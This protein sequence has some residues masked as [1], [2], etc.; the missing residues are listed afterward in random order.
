M[1][2]NIVEEIFSCSASSATAIIAG[3]RQLTFRDLEVLVDQ[4]AVQLGADGGQRIGLYCPNGI[5]HIVWSLAVLKCGGVLVPI[6]PELSPF[7]RD[8]Q[9]DITGVDAILCAD[10]RKWHKIPPHRRAL[11][12]L[13]L[14]T[15]EMTTG[16]RFTA[17]CFDENA[18]ASL[19]PAL[20]RF[21]SGTTGTSK[22]VV[23]SHQTLLDR[24]RAS[25]SH[26][27]L[28]P[29]DRV[30]WMLPMAHHF[31]VS[32]ILYLLHGATTVLENSHLGEDVF[33]AL[34]RH[35][36]TA[37]YASPFHY[38]L[39]ASCVNGKPVSSL[40]FAVST[41]AA[42]PVETAKR[43]WD[44]FGVPLQQALGIIECGLPLLNDFWPLDKP[45]SVGRPQLG[46]ETT[47]RDAKGAELAPGSVGDLF[48]RGPGFVDAY[49][50]PWK[51]QEE[52]LQ[53]GWFRSGDQAMVD[54][55][56]AVFLVGRSQSVINVGGMKCFPEE[57]EAILNSHP[58]VRESRVFA[59]D[60]ATFGS[61]P[62]A[63]IVPVS[64]DDLPKMSELSGW[65]RARLSL[66][67]L[68]VKFNFVVAVPKTASGKIQ[69]Q[70]RS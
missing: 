63:E 48:L 16:W 36:G 22:G 51:T 40:R 57:V 47:I 15:A 7:E 23:L 2:M 64:G 43:F 32:I 67:K 14:A 38:A 29:G 65:C 45:E 17:P 8:T 31:A 30:I 55:D 58:M 13:G 52:I 1:E 18:L 35:R 37:L 10:G 26:M 25:N 66:Y 6:A 44:R 53:D 20:I 54:T 9:V 61:V 33:A 59:A 62:T 28:G 70:H 34:E 69:R 39:L 11:D 41:A 27:R 60:H 49:L 24:V 19:S 5:G 68:P 4:A 56:G 46:F 50:S 21:S 12:V 42:L 3:E